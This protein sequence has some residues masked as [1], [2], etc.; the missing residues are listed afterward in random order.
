MPF[1]TFI[2]KAIDLVIDLIASNKATLVVDE[3]P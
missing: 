2:K 1:P 3:L